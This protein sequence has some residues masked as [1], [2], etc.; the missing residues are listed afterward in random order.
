MNKL[1]TL[2]AN[3]EFLIIIFLDLNIGPNTTIIF[4]E[5]ILE[6]LIPTILNTPNKNKI[7]KNCKKYLRFFIYCQFYQIN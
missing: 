2:F 4:S 6:N 3:K 5:I 7:Q 1:K